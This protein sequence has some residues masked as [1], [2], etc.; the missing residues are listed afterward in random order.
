M[1]LQSVYFR[2]FFKTA[3][4]IVRCT[5]GTLDCLHC[6]AECSNQTV[7]R[8]ETASGETY[9]RACALFNVRA[10]QFISVENALLRDRALI[11][12]DSN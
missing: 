9:G 11:N 3:V 5:R 7:I 6:F 12:S 10:K 8:E 4:K 1:L 2:T